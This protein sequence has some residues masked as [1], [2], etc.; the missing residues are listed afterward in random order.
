MWLKKYNLKI[1]YD[2][3]EVVMIQC[4]IHYSSCQDI[5]K[6]EKQ[7]IHIFILNTCRLGLFPT[8]ANNIENVT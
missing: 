2:T 5:C 3:E 1:N 4:P 8:L 6:T 7:H